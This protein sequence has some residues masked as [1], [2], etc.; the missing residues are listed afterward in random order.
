MASAW[1]N[2]K[3]KKSDECY[4]HKWNFKPEI[5]AIF[6]IDGVSDGQMAHNI[7]LHINITYLG[8]L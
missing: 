4:N 3:K 5:S 1:R 7:I 2:L 6:H 8:S